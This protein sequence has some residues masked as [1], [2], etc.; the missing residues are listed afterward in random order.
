MMGTGRR[1]LWSVTGFVLLVISAEAYQ[2]EDHL[3]LPAL[4]RVE[5]DTT[6]Q[7]KNEVFATAGI[8][9]S[10]RKKTQRP[11]GHYSCIGVS[12]KYGQAD[13]NFENF[14][15]QNPFIFW[16]KIRVHAKS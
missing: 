10:K 2:D 9:S 6:N 13:R 4:N 5:L 11:K 1:Q 3:T 14:K 16:V 8:V 12:Q 7:V 15:A